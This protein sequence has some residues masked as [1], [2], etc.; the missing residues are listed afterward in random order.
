MLQL[1]FRRPLRGLELLFS[2][3]WVLTLLREECVCTCTNGCRVGESDGVSSSA[4]RDLTSSR[5]KS[6]QMQT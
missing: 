4:P 6:C 1:L 5:V 3:R 2:P